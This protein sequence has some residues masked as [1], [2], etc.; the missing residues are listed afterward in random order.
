[1]LDEVGLA[2]A[3]TWYVQGFAQRSGIDVDLDLPGELGRFPRGLELAVFRIVQE[4]LA[5][6]HRHSGARR[7]CIRVARH[8]SALSLEVQDDG[9]GFEAVPAAAGE[10]FLPMGVGIA[11][12]RERARQFGGSLNIES[13]P[14]GT[15]VKV[16]LPMPGKSR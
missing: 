7:A 13:S 12:M 1:M 8:P 6:I 15:V 2:S 14:R 5:N 16:A 10:G 3:L 11:G 4:G 9:T